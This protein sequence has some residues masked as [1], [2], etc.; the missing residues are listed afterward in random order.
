M[1]DFA[2][3]ADHLQVQ[4]LHQRWIGREEF[5]HP[6]VWIFLWTHKAQSLCYSPDVRIDRKV[7]LIER[8]E[9]HDPGRLLSNPRKRQEPL[10][11]LVE[12]KIGEK[13]HVERSLFTR[14]TLQHV[15]DSYRLLVVQPADLDCL[16][17]FIHRGVLHPFEGSE[18]LEKRAVR[19]VAV[20]VA[21]VL[22]EDRSDQLLNRS[23]PRDLDLAVTIEQPLRDPIDVLLGV[24]AQEDRDGEFTMQAVN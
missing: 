17:D 1:T 4:P 9:H 8:E 2:A 22:R 6:L 15:L 24:H 23:A 13:R 11:R 20:C 21:C 14:D 5:V 18:V 12:R 3:E 19:V 7:R 16:S 10:H